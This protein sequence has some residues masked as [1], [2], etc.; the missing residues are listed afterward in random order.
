[1]PSQSDLRLE[2]LPHE[3]VDCI[4][5]CLPLSCLPSV[6]L[7]CKFGQAL[8]DS[9][10]AL[11]AKPYSPRTQAFEWL[12]WKPSRRAREAYFVRTMFGKRSAGLVDLEHFARHSMPVC[13]LWDRDDG[14]GRV[15]YAH[16]HELS[17]Y[18]VDELGRP[19][20]AWRGSPQPSSRPTRHRGPLDDIVDIAFLDNKTEELFVSRLSGSLQ[21]MRFE[22]D[23]LHEVAR[24]AS[25][26]SMVCNTM[27]T[28]DTLLI[29]THTSRPGVP[30]RSEIPNRLHVRPKQA[31]WFEG[32]SIELQSKP[33]SMLCIDSTAYVGGA[34]AAPLTSYEIASDRVVEDRTFQ[35]GAHAYSLSA[36]PG[37]KHLVVVGSYDGRIGIYDARAR[38]RTAQQTF[39]DRFSDDPV[40]SVS[41]NENRIVAGGARHSSLR[42]FDARSARQGWTTFLAR[43]DSPVYSIVAEGRHIFTATE[44]KAS[45]LEWSEFNNITSWEHTS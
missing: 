32:V 13:R 36:V 29:T 6:A 35:V 25:H 15:V 38:Q 24:Y 7:S 26:S 9:A 2:T 17:F 10:F 45:L 40:Y 14:H 12:H 4:A 21:R 3:V 1:M 16:G 41:I 18:E 34:S 42:F 5:P 43:D 8:A 37:N 33:W 44:R 31:P 22:R 39:S 11:Y 20:C 19:F 28:N 23:G 27:T 30:Q